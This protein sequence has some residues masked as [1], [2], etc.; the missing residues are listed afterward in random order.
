MVDFTNYIH[1]GTYENEVSL[2]YIFRVL[3][4][5]LFKKKMVLCMDRNVNY[6]I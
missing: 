4:N 5:E 3:N 1:N 6:N 2:C